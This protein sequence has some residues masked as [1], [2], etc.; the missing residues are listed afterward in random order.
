M[1]ATPGLPHHRAAVL[2]PS[3]S[4]PSPPRHHNAVSAHPPP[5][6]VTTPIPRVSRFSTHPHRC[7]SCT[8]PIRP[9]PPA[10]LPRRAAR[11]THTSCAPRRR[12]PCPAPSPSTALAAAAPLAP[13]SF[14][15]PSDVAYHALA[16]ANVVPSLVPRASTL[17]GVLVS[18]TPPRATSPP[19]VHRITHC[20]SIRTP[21]RRYPRSSR[22][23]HL[24]IRRCLANGGPNEIN[25]AGKNGTIGHQ[26]HR[27]TTLCFLPPASGASES[28]LSDPSTYRPIFT[29]VLPFP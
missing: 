11:R 23:P 25:V 10:F 24:R 28:P 29:V 12:R 26:P 5:L 13:P 9:L 17:D 4:S 18:R 20:I 27:L 22:T 6:C 16:V 8:P 3:S 2:L 21:P 15:L 14:A 1:V 19:H 7:T